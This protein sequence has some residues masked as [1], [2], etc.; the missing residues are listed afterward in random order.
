M[1]TWAE[2]G[3]GLGWGLQCLQGVSL[4]LDHTPPPQKKAPFPKMR[5][6]R[7]SPAQCIPTSGHVGL[8]DQGFQLPTRPKTGLLP[9]VT[10]AVAG[11]APDPQTPLSVG[12]DGTPQAPARRSR[13]R[14]SAGLS[15]GDR[16]DRLVA[17]ASE[18]TP[19]GH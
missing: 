11:A 17:Q 1:G 14:L 5:E 3:V 6:C 7:L 15:F 19:A 9:D 10:P 13:L 16:E 8:S 2:L 12:Q 4:S 18:G